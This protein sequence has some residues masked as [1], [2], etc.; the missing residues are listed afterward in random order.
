[1]RLPSRF[2][3]ELLALTLFSLAAHLP[4][5]LDYP[6]G[7]GGD[8]A[9]LAIHALDFLQR[10]VWPFYIYRLEAPNPL[11]VYLQ[12]PLFLT[13]GFNRA[14][15]RGLTVAA[16]AL[17][18]PAA[19]IT[20]RELFPGQPFAR[21]AGIMAALGLALSPFF[22]AFARIGTEHLL[23]PVLAL[24]TVALLWRGL[25]TGRKIDFVL[26]GLML[27][28]SQYSYLVA[29][30]FAV[31]VTGAC[32][33]ALHADRQLLA[34]WRGLA[35][36][37]ATSVVVII[38]QL[39]LFIAAPHTI[40]SRA[41]QS[42]GQ[43]VFTL[44]D[45]LRL[46]ATKL[47]YQLLMLCCQWQT[48]YNPF[49]GRPLLHPIFFVGLLLA[50]VV[51]VRSSSGHRFLLT[52]T[53]LMFV[54][55]LITYE[56]LWPSATR[57]SGAAPFVFIVAAVGCA[58]LWDW[59][60]K[61]SRYGW[62]IPALVLIACAESQWD[63]HRRVIPQ[64]MQ[65]EGLEWRASLVEMAEADYVNAHL[66][67]PILIPSSE[68]QRVTLTFLLADHFP[69]RAGGTTAPL[70][71]GETVTVISPIAPDRPTSDGPAANYI[72][73]QWVLLKDRTAYFLPPLPG[74][75]QITGEAGQIRASNGVIAANTYPALWLGQRPAVMAASASFANGLDLVG[76]QATALAPGQPVT[77]TLYW[78]RRQPL[79]ADVQLF[80][81]ILD[82]D[83]NA[84]AAIHDWPLHGVYRVR[85]WQDDEVVPLSY[86]LNIP[87]GATPG[88][89]RLI[90]GVFDVLQ[91]NRIPSSTGEE[92]ATVARLKIPLPVTAAQPAQRLSVRFGETIQLSG[93]TLTPTAGGLRLS[94]FWQ[95]MAAPDFDYT[96]FVHVV[97]A[98]GEIVGQSDS[99]PLAGQYPTSIWSP[100]ETI[101]DERL[102]PV[103]SGDDQ[104]FVGLYRLDTGER[105]PAVVNGTRAAE[106]RVLLGTGLTTP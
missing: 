105:L 87:P 63:F 57:I 35:L 21:R 40:A 50:A 28:L 41:Q 74:S 60:E 103:V 77:V 73:D 100:G 93:Y 32:L 88:P 46:L 13:F 9:Q 86:T 64:A 84:V 12:A 106:D 66:S 26:A 79:P 49:S 101:V 38:P 95:A 6:P 16:A 102:I 47:L 72:P 92:V 90:A 94:L 22:Q 58:R 45:P 71:D 76:Y 96:V 3:I 2:R 55:D 62:L 81:Q 83:G 14:V 78:R 24:I 1:M 7:I 70:T 80:T 19:Y 65:A 52:L 23:L 29:R 56:G 43:L 11:I 53:A 18:S 85:A 97:N 59:L 10:G 98:K 17:A 25:R 39:T 31:A 27:G 61:R 54:P 30:G 33:V 82:R 51:A 15:L 4:G 42:A 8:S 44:P 68:Y 37:A 36:A 75:I 48:G 89:Y 69:N 67:T 104:V 91:N 20:A 5:Y 99:A 34:R